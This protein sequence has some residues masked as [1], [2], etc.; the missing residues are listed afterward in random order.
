MKTNDGGRCDPTDT[1]VY[2]QSREAGRG[3]LVSVPANDGQRPLSARNYFWV[4]GWPSAAHEIHP[5]AQ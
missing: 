1:R 2:P 3:C 5:Q 4:L